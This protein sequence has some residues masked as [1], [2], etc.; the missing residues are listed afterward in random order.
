MSDSVP[1]LAS[2]AATRLSRSW[3]RP[4]QVERLD[5]V[6]HHLD[7]HARDRLTL[8]ELAQIAALAPHH[9]HRLFR[10]YTGERVQTLARRLRLEQ[11]AFELFT[12]ATAV[13]DIA[14]GCGFLSPAAFTRAFRRHF[15]SPPRSFREAWPADGYHV[16]IAPGLRAQFEQQPPEL[17]LEPPKH[18]KFLRRR[19]PLLPSAHDAYSAATRLLEPNAS[20]TAAI[21]ERTP[22]FPPITPPDRLR[23]DAGFF[24]GCAHAASDELFEQTLPGGRYAVFHLEAGAEAKDVIVQLWN[25][26]Y[27]EWA[28]RHRKRIAS[29]G[30]YL[31]YRR[32]AGRTRRVEVHVPLHDAC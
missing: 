3:L 8:Q 15:G 27:L 11:A 1:A 25:F 18:L 31:V 12:S 21:V 20:G 22:D 32:H 2:P 16:A 23:N 17:C 24:H 26:A 19:G 9:F 13:R 10:R 14:S 29:F 30:A 4:H 6:L 28:P 5:R 7:R